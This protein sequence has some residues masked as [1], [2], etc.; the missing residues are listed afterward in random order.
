MVPLSNNIN[1]IIEARFKPVGGCDSSDCD[2]TYEQIYIRHSYGIEPPTISITNFPNT[3][4]IFISNLVD[5]IYLSGVWTDDR[6][7]TEV[8]WNNS[9]ILT[10]GYAAITGVG[11]K[12]GTWSATVPLLEYSENNIIITATDNDDEKSYF[13]IQVEV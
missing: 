1:Q 9:T 7:V 12:I 3:S 8:Q 13:P 11:G 10:N 2:E 4:S 6:T 5:E